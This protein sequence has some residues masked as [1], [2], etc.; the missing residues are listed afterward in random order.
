MDKVKFIFID[1]VMVALMYCGLIDGNE[2][3][4]NVFWPVFWVFCFFSFMVVIALSNEKM[5]K[6][7]II[8]RKPNPLWK[9]K[10]SFTYDLLFSLAL[11]A[12]GFHW[13]GAIWFVI[14][15]FAGSLVTAVDKELRLAEAE[16][17]GVKS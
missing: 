10:Y 6:E 1:A 4:A 5:K 7:A 11:A 9:E 15:L 2:Y 12:L 8:N 17:A 14:S 13:S 16:K 3:A